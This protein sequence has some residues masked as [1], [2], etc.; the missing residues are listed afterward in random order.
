MRTE[1]VRFDIDQKAIGSFTRSSHGMVTRWNLKITNEIKAHV[2]PFVAAGTMKYGSGLL[3]RSFTV[4]LTN[5][6]ETFCEV[7]LKNSQPYAAYRFLGTRPVIGSGHGLMPVGK[8][9][10]RSIG[11]GRVPNGWTS[12]KGGFRGIT[13]RLY[14]KGQDGNNWPLTSM[15]WVLKVKHKVLI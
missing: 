3:A 6:G 9:Q 13:P 2:V 7:H 4:V 14:V 12:P 15:R 5:S 11:K 10:F 1:R 8:S